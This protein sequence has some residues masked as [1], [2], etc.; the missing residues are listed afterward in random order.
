MSFSPNDIARP[1]LS[2]QW[3]NVTFLHWRIDTA[4][5][6][7]LMPPGVVPDEFD[8]SSWVGL[9]PFT[10]RNTRFGPSP[11]LPFYGTF[12]ETNVRLYARDAEGRKGVV[13]LSLE[14]ERLAAVAAARAAFALPYI[15]SHMR[16]R[17]TAGTLVYTSR[18]HSSPRGSVDSAIS[19]R[20]GERIEHP[21]AL[22]D[23]LTARW[24]LFSRQFGRTVYM[25]N[26]HQPWPLQKA[27]L[28]DFSD[29]LLSRA[30]LPGVANRPPDSILFSPGVDTVF[31]S[32]Q[33]LHLPQ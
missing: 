3:R 25:P 9:I 17:R 21:D 10:L 28:L 2:Q 30:G 5:A 29:T 22:A 6:A 4:D 11:A 27:E 20:P 26:K 16:V 12:H 33:K 32:P 7:S 14:A 19:V 31:G 13:F 15:W 24:A 23:F 8:G 18:R 1:I